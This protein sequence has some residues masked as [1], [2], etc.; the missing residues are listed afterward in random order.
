[1]NLKHKRFLLLTLLLFIN[2]LYNKLSKV[3]NN[4]T[5]CTEIELR[6][7]FHAMQCFTK[8]KLHTRIL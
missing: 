6:S 4:F 1:M 5:S 8:T 7:L 2:S 3:S